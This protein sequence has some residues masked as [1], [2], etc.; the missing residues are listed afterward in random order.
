MH[1]TVKE[2]HDLQFTVQVNRKYIHS[3]LG[4]SAS[5]SC[6]SYDICEA[7]GLK[8]WTLT[9]V[10]FVLRSASSNNYQPMGYVTLTLILGNEVITHN[11]IVCQSLTKGLSIGLLFSVKN[12]LGGDWSLDEK[13]FLHK[14]RNLLNLHIKCKAKSDLLLIPDSVKFESSYSWY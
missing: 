12:R 14:T 2:E 5:K 1:V 8:H 10:H 11:F 4:T 13:F 3:L 9:K 6:I 7:I